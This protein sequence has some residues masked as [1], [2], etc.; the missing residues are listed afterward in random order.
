MYYATRLSGQRYPSRNQMD[1]EMK[2]INVFDDATTVAV[3]RLEMLRT[4]TTGSSPAMGFP[5]DIPAL[6]WPIAAEDAA[7]FATNY[8]QSS[9]GFGRI[10]LERDVLMTIRL[11]LEDVQ[12][13][14]VAEM[15]DPEIWAAIDI[16]KKVRRVPIAFKFEADD[17]WRVKLCTPEIPPGR[18]SNEQYRSPDR[19]PTAHTWHGLASLVGSGQI[20]MGASSDIPGV[21]LRHV[22]VNVLLTKRL[23]QFTKEQSLVI[24][25]D[26]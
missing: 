2:G 4:L 6:T 9:L 7:C 12:V 10:Q 25:D 13:Y 8:R 22:F 20:Q 11:Q 18:L 15:T 19:A 14:W 26:C 21:A 3:G 17:Q 23:E 5:R 16:W 24:L 1:I